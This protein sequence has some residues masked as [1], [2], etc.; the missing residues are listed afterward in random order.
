MRVLHYTFSYASPSDS[1]TLHYLTDLHIG[2]RACAE[3]LLSEHVKTIQDTPNAYW[4]GGGDY[5]DAICHLGDKR[6]K[7]ET[8]AKWTLGKTDIMG[9]QR[10]KALDFLLPIADKC[11][12]LGSGNH[13]WIADSRYGRSLYWEIVAA[14]AQKKGVSPETIGYGVQGF[15]SLSFRRQY[16]NSVGQKWRLVI[17]AHHGYGHSRLAGGAALTLQRLLGDYQCDLAFM[18]HRHTF[19]AVSKIRTMAG[20]T[21]VKQH[22]SWALF[23]PGYLDQYVP[24]GEGQPVDTYTEL[25]ALPSQPLGT[26]PVLIKPYERKF[27]IYLN[28]GMVGTS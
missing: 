4:I 20:Q 18:G 16:E 19:H 11:L 21:D 3:S 26:V 5:I 17:F 7:P 14:I 6:Y 10:D 22:V 28:S 12:G 23:V 1:F 27:I 15:I 13:E 9:V 25:F 24:D 2:A 8:L